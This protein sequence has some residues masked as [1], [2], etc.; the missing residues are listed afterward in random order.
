VA[1]HVGVIGLGMM[2][3]HYLQR[4]QQAGY[5]VYALDVNRE[6]LQWAQEQGVTVAV[7]PKH[8]AQACE[9]ILLAV[10]GNREVRAVTE[11][12]SGVFAALRPGHLLVNTST[13]HP[14]LDEEMAKRCAERDA[15]WID[16]PVTWR[17]QGLIVMVGGEQKHVARAMPMLEAIAYKV[18]HVGEVGAG[19]RLKAVNQLIGVCQLA[20]WCEAAEFARSIG[21]SPEVIRDVLEL[22]IPD[23]VLGEDFTGSGQLVLHYK[24]LGYILELAHEHEAAVPLTGIVHEVFKAVKHLGEPDWAQPGIVTYWRRMNRR[25][26]ERG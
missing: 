9:V 1:E 11:A 17:A 19:Q 21:L 3:R 2:G 25:Q 26:D 23:S 15:A 14:R 5:A 18:A 10:T 22:P 12:D 20:V 24:D 8:L 4:L 7:S 6:R 16:A 13:T